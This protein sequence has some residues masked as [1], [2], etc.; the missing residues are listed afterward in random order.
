MVFIKTVETGKAVD[1]FTELITDFKLTSGVVS[2]VEVYF[3]PG[4]AGL[5]KVKLLLN[6]KAFIPYNADDFIIGDNVNLSYNVNQSIK[7]APFILTIITENHDYVYP[8]QI[9]VRIVIDEEVNNDDESPEV[10]I[11]QSVDRRLTEL[12]EVIKEATTETVN[13]PVSVLFKRK[14]VQ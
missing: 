1:S 9:Q 10:L 13:K 2:L 8:H 6:E 4:C 3:P 7:E 14:R 11:L 5:H 12:N